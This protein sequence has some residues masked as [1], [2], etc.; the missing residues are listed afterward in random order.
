[1]YKMRRWGPNQAD[2]WSLISPRYTGIHS[3]LKPYTGIKFHFNLLFFYQ[4]RTP[5][6]WSLQL[7]KQVKGP[8]EWPSPSHTQA[9]SQS[10][11]HVYRGAWAFSKSISIPFVLVR[12]QLASL[13]LTPYQH[14]DGQFRKT[15][16]QVWFLLLKKKTSQSS[17]E[18]PTFKTSHS[19]PIKNYSS[20]KTILDSN[21][22]YD[23]MSP[24][25]LDCYLFW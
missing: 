17:L 1:M 18:R 21:R 11:S 2:S 19:N 7:Q 25:Q 15:T 5:Q 23:A 24:S 14:H 12:R 10:P 13:C 9:Y 6:D 22:N 4:K 16:G 20:D 8:P 3:I